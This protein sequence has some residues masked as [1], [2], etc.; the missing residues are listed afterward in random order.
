M[1][2]P[3][4][5]PKHPAVML[6]VALFQS[7]P[8]QSATDIS[9]RVGLSVSRMARLFKREMGISLVDYRNELKMK[10]FFRLV[11]NSGHRRPNLLLAALSAGYRSYGHFHRMFRSR[12]RVGPR[13]YFGRQTRTSLSA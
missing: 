10:R 3:E 5:T 9:P 2:R 12:W 4:R 1:A 7:D 11:Q 8:S 6:M 13:E